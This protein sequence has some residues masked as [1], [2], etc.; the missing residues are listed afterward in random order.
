MQ[1]FPDQIMADAC[2]VLPGRLGNGEPGIPA[3]Y[4]RS[5][6]LD[7]EFAPSRT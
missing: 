7:S 1:T 3:A 4:P 2:R 5:M 6:T